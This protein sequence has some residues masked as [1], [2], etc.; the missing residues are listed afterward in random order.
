MQ[1]YQSLHFTTGRLTLRPLS[2]ADTDALY[3]IFSD[4]A[5][6]RHLSHPA[7][8]DRADAEREIADHQAAMASNSAV[9]LGIFVTATGTLAGTVKLSYFVAD[10][11]RCEVGYALGVAHWGRGYLVEAMQVLLD[12]A[13]STLDMNRIEADID[14]ANIAS[15]KTLARL[16]FVQEGLLR[17]RWIVAGVLSDTAMYGLLRRDWGGFRQARSPDRHP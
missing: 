15:A 17:E 8:T 9:K 13:F 14:P 7:W 16:G 5:V 2:T 12:F 4:P 10:S 3:A 6:A 1:N 11:R